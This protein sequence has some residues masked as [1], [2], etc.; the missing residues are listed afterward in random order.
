M[1][2]ERAVLT[3]GRLLRA[4]AGEFARHGYA[5]T[6]LQEVCRSAGVSMGA[7]TFHF[8]TKRSLAEAV[9]EAGAAEVRETVAG[10][11]TC[12][13]RSLVMVARLTSDIAALLAVSPVARAAAHL[14]KELGES[15]GGWRAVWRPSVED[16]LER[17]RQRKELAPGVEAESVVQL[18]E[19]LLCGAVVVVDSEA[20]ATGPCPGSDAG[21]ESDRLGRIWAAVMHGV[22][23]PAPPD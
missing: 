10:V 23:A 3:R 9:A 1:K 12:D 7:L 6:S 16:L 11:M 19:R 17:A 21:A 8:S 22:R 20:A 5:G 14:E 2:Q 13:A 15:V 4:A 18:T